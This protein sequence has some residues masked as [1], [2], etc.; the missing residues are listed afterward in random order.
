MTLVKFVAGYLALRSA[1]PSFQYDRLRGLEMV[2][3]ASEKMLTGFVGEHMRCLLPFCK[4]SDHP[5]VTYK[6]LMC[7]RHCSK[8]SVR[9]FALNPHNADDA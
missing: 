7:V 2:R 9:I 4:D 6:D 5:T 1:Q 8:C 3:V